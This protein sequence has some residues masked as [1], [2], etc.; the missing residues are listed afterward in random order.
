MCNL[1]QDIDYLTNYIGSG[2]KV[3][4]KKDNEYYSPTIGI[5][6]NIGPVEIPTVQI[7]YIDLIIDSILSPNSVAY[8]ETMIGRTCVF[9]DFLAA[10]SIFNTWK[11]HSRGELTIVKMTVSKD[12]MIG[13]YGFYT[14]VGG[15]EIVRI[16]EL[17]DFE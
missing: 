15:K 16:R 14:V 6:Y 7:N 9:M 5:K 17:Y 10:K 13:S 11:G 12:L 8:S 2:Y 3:V 4:I 1:E